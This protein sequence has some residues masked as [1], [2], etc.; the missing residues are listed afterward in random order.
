MF[1]V[2]VKNTDVFYCININELY[3]HTAYIYFI[4]FHPLMGSFYI[5]N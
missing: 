3:T 2:F 4:W 5:N 1:Q